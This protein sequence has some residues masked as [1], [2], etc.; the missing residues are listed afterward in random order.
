MEEEIVGIYDEDHGYE[1]NCP[2]CGN[3]VYIEEYADE[4]TMNQ[5]Y[6]EEIVEIYCENCDSYF[7]AQLA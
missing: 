1:C 7:K 2:N 4:D 5:I 3:T 6:D